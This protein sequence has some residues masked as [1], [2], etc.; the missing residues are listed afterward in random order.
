MNDPMKNTSKKRLW[1]AIRFIVAVAAVGLAVTFL[2]RLR[3]QSALGEKGSMAQ[4][5]RAAPSPRNES[6]ANPRATPPAVLG[7]ARSVLPMIAPSKMAASLTSS[8]AAGPD[9]TAVSTTAA[10]ANIAAVNQSTEV[11]ATARMYAAHA[12]LR[13][14]EVA[15]PDSKTNQQILQTMVFKALSQAAKPLR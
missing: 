7:S 14:P 10:P 12:S 1:T 6:K 15:D 9:A 8:P 11:I 4:I 3:T 13:E 5:L 2:M